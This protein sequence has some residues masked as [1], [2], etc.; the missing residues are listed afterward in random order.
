MS[1][2]LR[3]S[4][5]LCLCNVS[6]FSKDVARAK[7][8]RLRQQAATCLLVSSIASDRI[9]LLAAAP[10]MAALLLD[11]ARA[12]GLARPA[13]C[14]NRRQVKLF[15]I[16]TCEPRKKLGWPIVQKQPAVFGQDYG[17]LPACSL[18]RRRLSRLILWSTK[19][20]VAHAHFNVFAALPNFNS[21]GHANQTRLA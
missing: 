21:N 16:F 19:E 14:C 10:L 3:T 9:Y 13:N 7:S 5:E 12:H 11:C 2:P 18:R 20:T 1:K 4:S 6:A 15:K 17:N 8:R